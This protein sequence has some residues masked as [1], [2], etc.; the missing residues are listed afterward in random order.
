MA[1]PLD[2]NDSETQ[3]PGE[4][5]PQRKRFLIQMGAVA[6]VSAVVGG[7]AAAWFLPQNADT[8]ACRGSGRG[9][10]Q[11]PYRR[12]YGRRYIKSGRIL[13]NVFSRGVFAHSS[14]AVSDESQR[15]GI[16]T[17]KDAQGLKPAVIL[18]CFWHD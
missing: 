15:C 2:S 1:N 7:L 8:A 11:I 18:G 12:N 13:A 5:G 14:L 17:A 16:G 4:T 3:K 10:F 9:R 6:A